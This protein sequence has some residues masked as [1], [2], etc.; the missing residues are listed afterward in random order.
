LWNS[1]GPPQGHQL[2]AS[3]DPPVPLQVEH[4]SGGAATA[5]GIDQPVL[6]HVLYFAWFS[7]MAAAM[8]RCEF[9]R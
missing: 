4:V 7:A 8:F 3:R 5:A 9:Q 1:F 2:E 6:C